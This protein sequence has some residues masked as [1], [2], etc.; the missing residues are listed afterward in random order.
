[1]FPVEIK[2]KWIA[3]NVVEP[4]PDLP[5]GIIKPGGASDSSEHYRG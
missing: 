2:P 1:M 3:K 5:E 4:D